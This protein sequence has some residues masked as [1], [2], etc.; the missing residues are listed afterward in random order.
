MTKDEAYNTL[1]AKVQAAGGYI[2]IDEDSRPA[3]V[4]E[5]KIIGVAAIFETADDSSPLRLIDTDLHA[6]DIYDY[7]DEEDIGHIMFMGKI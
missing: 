2:R 1:L 7:L 4:I 3:V 6:W 5:E